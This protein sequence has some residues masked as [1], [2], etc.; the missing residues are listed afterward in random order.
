MSRQTVVIVTLVVALVGA[1][2]V[3]A[4]WYRW[5]QRHQQRHAAR[6]DSRFRSGDGAGADTA[7][8]DGGGNTDKEDDGTT[9]PANGGAGNGAGAGNNGGSNDG[10]DSGGG[11][12][13]G[14][15][16]STDTG[17]NTLESGVET[18]DGQT[19][20]SIEID[21]RLP[22]E[23]RAKFVKLNQNIGKITIGEQ[24]DQMMVLLQQIDHRQQVLQRTLEENNLLGAVAEE[25]EKRS[26][27]K[28]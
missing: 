10:A 25:L 23:D 22:P 14:G 7:G 28:K 8:G 3:N 27:S 26:G 9:P 5:R 21:P 1:S 4:C 12:D 2:T 24:L 18:G 16:T 11:A 13:N 15:G 20:V 17:D 19:F 6:Y